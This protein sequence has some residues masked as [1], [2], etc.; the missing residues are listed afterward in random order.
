[1]PQADL[2]F[3]RD[4]DS[5][6]VLEWLENLLAKQPKAFAKVRAKLTLLEQ[7]GNDLRRPAADYLE[8][9]IYELRA[10]H[11]NVNYRLLYFFHGKNV[12]ILVHG[13]TKEKEIPKAD[14]KRAKDRKKLFEANTS[15]H[16]YEEEE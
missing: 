16:T 6:P 7:L 10:R 15:A 8:D 3:Y 9:G 14:L 11:K 5:V 13:L 2:I 1:M 4:E 12:V